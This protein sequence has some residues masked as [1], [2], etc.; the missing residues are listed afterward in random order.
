MLI[1]VRKIGRWRRARWASRQGIHL[2]VG[3]FCATL[4]SV[5][6]GVPEWLNVILV[7]VFIVGSVLT[8]YGL[9]LEMKVSRDVRR[10]G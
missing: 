10:R 9:Y 6:L 8:F 5:S 4:F 2:Q 7:A 3:S 1:P